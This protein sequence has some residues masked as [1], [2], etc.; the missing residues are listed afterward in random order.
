MSGDHPPCETGRCWGPQAHPLSLQ[1]L[2]VCQPAS[3]GTGVHRELP[4][5]AGSPLPAF[6]MTPME[7]QPQ[8]PVPDGNTALRSPRCQ[9]GSLEPPDPHILHPLHTYVL[10]GSLYTVNTILPP[11]KG[12]LDHSCSFQK[13]FS[14]LVSGKREESGS[15]FILVFKRPILIFRSRK[16]L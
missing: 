4:R 14:S 8:A 6:E 7:D 16:N 15:L 5:P 11:T 13:M 3:Q 10:Q 9:G 2:L 12:C 1:P